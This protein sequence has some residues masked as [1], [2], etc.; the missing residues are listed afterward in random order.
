MADASFSALFWTIQ[1]ISNRFPSNQ[2]VWGATA[3]VSCKLSL[4]ANPSFPTAP[5]AGIQVRLS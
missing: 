2:P 1:L 3:D 5:L 4:L